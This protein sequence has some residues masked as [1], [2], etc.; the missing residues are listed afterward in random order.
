MK[1]GD[2]REEFPDEADESEFEEYELHRKY[3]DSLDNYFYE[4]R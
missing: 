2:D 3:A 4:D 1:I